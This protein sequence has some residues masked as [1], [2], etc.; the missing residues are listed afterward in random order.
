MGMR[1]PENVTERHHYNP[2]DGGHGVLCL[3]RAVPYQAAMREAA[4][5]IQR[6][7]TSPPTVVGQLN[8]ANAQSLF[9]DANVP[10]FSLPVC[11]L[12]YESTGFRDSH[13]RF[14]RQRLREVAGNVS[15]ADPTSRAAS[16]QYVLASAATF[17]ATLA[18]L[19]LAGESTE[20][21]VVIVD[22]R[23]RKFPLV[24]SAE[25][26]STAR[27]L[28][29]V[30]QWSGGKSHPFVRSQPVPKQDPRSPVLTVV[31]STFEEH[32]LAPSGPDVLVML[33][34]PWS[35]LCQ[36]LAPHFDALAA[37]AAQSPQ[38]VSD[39]RCV[40]SILKPKCV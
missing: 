3:C 19:G 37:K 28:T 18:D 27:L 4:R 2:T 11:I 35:K 13:V 23:V 1:R 9:G 32:V 31:G 25:E 12:F 16:L 6:A 5:W 36:A 20:A 15:A 17:K 34:E 29:F 39:H 33:F 14:W 7:A 26:L 40:R 24:D 38:R 10:F 30:E 22:E 8:V 21:A